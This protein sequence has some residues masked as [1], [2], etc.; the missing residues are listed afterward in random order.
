LALFRVMATEGAII[1]DPLIKGPTSNW[2][3]V[4]YYEYTKQT[5]CWSLRERAA[6]ILCVPHIKRMKMCQ[7]VIPLASTSLQDLTN[8]S[9]SYFSLTNSLLLTK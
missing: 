6:H 2:M 9:L 1:L 4:E 7:E 5:V 3:M 8:G